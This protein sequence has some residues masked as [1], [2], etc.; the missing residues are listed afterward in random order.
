[1]LPFFRLKTRAEWREY[2]C[3]DAF[4]ETTRNFDALDILLDVGE[5]DLKEF[6]SMRLEEYFDY[7]LE[8][9]TLKRWN[10]PTMRELAALYGGYKEDSDLMYDLFDIHMEWKYLYRKEHPGVKLY[11]GQVW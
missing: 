3:S 6:W 10:T 1:M 8:K 11:Y 4:K 9:E 7:E 5:L 2:I